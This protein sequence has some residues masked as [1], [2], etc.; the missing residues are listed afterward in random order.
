MKTYDLNLILL[1]QRSHQAW[2][3]YCPFAVE[4]LLE[5]YPNLSHNEI[6]DEQFRVLPNGQGQIFLKVRQYE[7][8]QNVPQSEWAFANVN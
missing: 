5:K 6:G 4:N 8:S 7:V 2:L 3:E 1:S